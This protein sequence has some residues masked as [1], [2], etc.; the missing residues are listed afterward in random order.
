MRT[1]YFALYMSL[2]LIGTLIR[3]P[4]CIILSRKDAYAG[5]KYA[6]ETM[7]NWANGLIKATGSKVIITG[8]ENIP[9][10]EVVVIISNHQSDFDIPLLVGKLDIPFGIISK[11]EVSKI[12][13]MGTW[14]K[15]FRCVLIDRS[16][17]RK[18]LVAIEESIDNIKNGYSQ[19]IFPEGTRSKSNNMKN[20]KHGAL[21]VA[22]KT[23][24][25]I[26]PIT[27]QNTF[28]VYEETGRIKSSTVKMVVH[29]PIYL[30]RMDEESKKNIAEIVE[31]TIRSGL[32]AIDN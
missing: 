11:K 23:D 4:K 12:P 21:K 13:I 25:T 7:H 20:I 14:M 24:A 30:R 27:V 26:L 2:T 16:S 6:Y 1:I 29:P 8:L 10:D 15:Y 3:L 28:R 32:K 9:K 5:F 19:L 31:N 17:P 22:T 18:S